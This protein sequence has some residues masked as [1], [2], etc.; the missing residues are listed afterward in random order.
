MDMAIKSSPEDFRVTEVADLP[1]IK[2]GEYRVYRLH[3]R[4]WNTIDA[5]QAISRQTKIP[6]KSFAYGGRKDRHASTSQYITVAAVDLPTVNTPEFS[7]EYIGCMDRPMGPDLIKGNAFEIVVRK[8]GKKIAADL[9]DKAAEVREYGFVNYFDDQR[10]GSWDP[11]QGFLAEKILLGHDNGAVKIYCTRVEGADKAADRTRKN[12]FAKHWRDWPACLEEAHTSWE[13]CAFTRLA[14]HPN[15]FIGILRL[16][17]REEM[18]MYFSAYESFLWN[19]VLRRFLRDTLHAAHT[20]YAGVTGDYLF[21]AELD[22]TKW[23]LLHQLIIPTLAAKLKMPLPQ[24]QQT[25]ADIFQERG[26]ED[27]LFN[28]LKIRHVYFKSIARPAVVLP[29][30]LSLHTA[31]DENNPGKYQAVL[32]FA[33]P[34]GS[35]GTMLLKRLFA[36]PVIDPR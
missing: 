15:D 3:K 5:L 4:G 26:L 14:E 16:I 6:F 22:K 35:Y 27:R 31:A 11:Q 28:R 21:F 30:K 36:R 23:S 12:F 33:L 34:R 2:S 8:L 13:R 1:L 19:E 18:S 9:Q 20:V 32:K 10:F 24:L 29:E 17:P 25:Y 7:C